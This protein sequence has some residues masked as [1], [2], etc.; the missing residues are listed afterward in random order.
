VDQDKTEVAGKSAKQS[1]DEILRIA[2]ERFKLSEEG[3]RDIRDDWIDDVKFCDGEQWSSKD[4]ASRDADGRPTIV[5]NKLTGVVHQVTN[6][7]RQNRSQIRINPVDDF[8]D[9]DTAKVIQGVVRNIEYQS[10]ADVAYDTAFEHQVK[11]GLGFL[12][13]VTEYC[14]HMSFDQELRI[15]RIRNPMTVRFDPGSKEPD[16]SDA[17][18]AFIV[19]DHTPDEFKIAFPKAK[20]VEAKDFD[21]LG[22]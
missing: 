19:E 15:K 22:R 16:G 4:K 11:G 20:H 3:F 6:E 1:D 8:T 10:N 13:V 12:R 21:T 18:W 7:Q 17:N 2:R 9:P 14:D 5:I